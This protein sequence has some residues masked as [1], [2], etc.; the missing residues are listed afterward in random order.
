[1][2][3]LIDEKACSIGLRSGEYGGRNMSLHSDCS[4]SY[5]PGNS[6]TTYELHRSVLEFHPCGGYYSYLEP[7]RYEVL[8]MDL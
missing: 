7:V 6:N 3:A 8:G 4:V 1:M 2:N 5:N